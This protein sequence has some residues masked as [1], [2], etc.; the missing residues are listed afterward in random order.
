VSEIDNGKTVE[1]K[2]L[3]EPIDDKSDGKI[4]SYRRISWI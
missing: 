1:S 4:C 3:I 2:V